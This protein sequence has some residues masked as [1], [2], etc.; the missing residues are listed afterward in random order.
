M[1]DADGASPSE[2]ELTRRMTEDL[3]VMVALRAAIDRGDMRAL[4]DGRLAAPA[5]DLALSVLRGAGVVAQGDGQHWRLTPEAADLWRRDGPAL[6]ARLRFGLMAAADLILHGEALFS[7]DRSFFG[8]AA[9][10]GFFRYAR[11]LGS[12]AA[13]IEDTEPWVRYV[14]AL[15]Q[16]EAPELAPLVPLAGC[17]RLLEIGGNVG[18]FALALLELHP[19][20]QAAVLDLPAVC[21]IGTRA[22]ATH[23]A[24]ARLKF[25]PGDIRSDDWPLI[26]DGKPDAIIFK[27]VLHDWDLARVPEILTRAARHLAPGGRII[28]IERGPLQAE[29][30][31]SGLSAATNLVFAPFYRAP[32][33]YADLLAGLGLVPLPPQSTVLDMTFHIIGAEKPA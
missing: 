7:D 24:A 12:G 2:T 18:G 25:V 14:A 15:N 3:P 26:G 1:S 17:R 6:E 10:Y 33:V 28:I 19:G 22:S 8:R 20:L 23:P 4:L 32:A 31:I 9:T 27:S 21:H 16:T 29:P 30:L 5:G 11:A 13:Q